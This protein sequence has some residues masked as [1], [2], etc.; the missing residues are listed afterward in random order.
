MRFSLPPIV[1]SLGLIVPHRSP[2]TEGYPELAL[3][4]RSVQEPQ[5][6][7]WSTVF[8]NCR[9]VH[10]GKYIRDVVHY[11]VV[12][13]GSRKAY[14][15]LTFRSI[16]FFDASRSYGLVAGSG[17]TILWYVSPQVHEFAACSCFQLARLS[18]KKSRRNA[19]VD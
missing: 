11:R 10:P 12:V 9:M 5:H 13:M 17:K 7:P 16:T 3:P 4:A 8:W 14:V 6:C 2:F 18:F 19:T 15:L 1:V